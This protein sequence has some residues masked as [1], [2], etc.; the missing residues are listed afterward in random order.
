MSVQDQIKEKIE[1]MDEKQRYM[2]FGAILLVIFLL[3]YFLLMSPQINKLIK[4]GTDVSTTKVDIEKAR[5][6]IA[7][8]GQYRAEVSDL[9]K[10]V[11]EANLTVKS[12]DELPLVLERISRAASANGVKI[13]QI[14]PNSDDQEVVVENDG[15]NYI[16]MPIFVQAR[17]GYHDFGRFINQ[18]E[19]GDVLLLVGS[20]TMQD[21]PND[22]DY[23]EIQMIL[24]AIIFE[25]AEVDEGEGQ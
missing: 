3:D 16:A 1:N 13:D 22:V 20:Y 25:E 9:R 11:K 15:I 18:L 12:K 23:H 10:E 19:S 17:S 21:S 4:I 8:E 5:N 6:D 24:N 2:A 14:I 7:R